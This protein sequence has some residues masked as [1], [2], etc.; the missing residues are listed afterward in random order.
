MNSFHFPF[1]VTSEGARTA[2]HDLPERG[3]LS[4]CP[5]QLKGHT[6]SGPH[7]QT[8]RKLPKAFAPLILLT[9]GP[10]WGFI[11]RA[12]RSTRYFSTDA[13]A[14]VAFRASRPSPVRRQG[15][16]GTSFWQRIVSRFVPIIIPRFPHFLNTC[17]LSMLIL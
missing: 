3:A 6:K 14:A 8:G 9:C 11:W 5:F 1:V 4:C 15:G 12:S 13:V 17:N 7:G 16:P 10:A 2:L